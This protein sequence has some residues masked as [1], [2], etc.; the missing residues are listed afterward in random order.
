MSH[1]LT[2]DWSETTT[3]SIMLAHNLSSAL[4]ELHLL[5]H[6]GDK[7]R[8]CCHSLCPLVH[9]KSLQSYSYWSPWSYYK[10]FLS[11]R[12]WSLPGC[13]RP[14]HS[15]QGLT[16]WSNENDYDVITED[17]GAT[18]YTCSIDAKMHWSYSAILVV[19][20]SPTSYWDNFCLKTLLS[21]IIHLY[22]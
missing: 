21:S 1:W 10:T 22:A 7:L 20:G 18:R 2:W 9:Y 11:W 14:I 12:E 4:C 6:F 13:L 8:L 15:A 5:L 19:H 17:V 3:F 16:E